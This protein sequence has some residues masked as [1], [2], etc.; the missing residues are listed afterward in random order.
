[1]RGGFRGIWKGGKQPDGAV[2]C[3]E[4]PPIAGSAW[5]VFVALDRTYGFWMASQKSKRNFMT[6]AN[7]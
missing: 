5:W 4:D 7:G 1:M 6:P 2:E 3:N